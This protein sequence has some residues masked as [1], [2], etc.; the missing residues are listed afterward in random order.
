MC[1]FHLNSKNS[2]WKCLVDFM[3]E[4]KRKFPVPST[5]FPHQLTLFNSFWRFRICSFCRG[6][7]S[8]SSSTYSSHLRKLFIMTKKIMA[9]KMASL[10][11]ERI[12][13]VCVTHEQKIK[14][15]KCWS[16]SESAVV[17]WNHKVYKV[18]Q[19]SCKHLF[20]QARVSQFETNSWQKVCLVECGH[21]DFFWNTMCQKK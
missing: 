13:E 12:W 8:K 18:I 10:H 14:R 21:T 1:K 11:P 15:I 9:C 5:F 7:E 4:R 16:V 2:F 20:T 6:S 17:E 3:F 19:Q